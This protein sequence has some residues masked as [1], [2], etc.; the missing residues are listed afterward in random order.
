MGCLMLWSG[1][2]GVHK[3]L[4]DVCHIWGGSTDVQCRVC[5][6]CFAECMQKSFCSCL[7]ACIAAGEQWQLQRS[8]Q[9]NLVWAV[10]QVQGQHWCAHAMAEMLVLHD[11]PHYFWTVHLIVTGGAA[12]LMGI[13]DCQICFA[14]CMQKTVRTCLQASIAIGQKWPLQLF[15]AATGAVSC[16]LRCC[17]LRRRCC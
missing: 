5:Q 1:S 2:T 7:Q 17:W 8:V 13:A 9:Q 14:K 15:A 3:A 16:R 6:I 12:A 4:L 11:K 10:Q